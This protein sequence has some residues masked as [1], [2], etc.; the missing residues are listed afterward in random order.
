MNANNKNIGI[1][2]TIVTVVL[3]GLPA[4][5]GLCLAMS[6]LYSGVTAGGGVVEMTGDEQT[7]LLVSGVA[8]LC[9]SVVFL[10]IPILVGFFTFRK[11]PTPK[12]VIDEP[13][14]PA[15]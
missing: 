1:V 14:P 9:I 2:A 12:P 8:T 11:K 10:L 5:I 4:L 3:C 15:S 13:I 6:F 7:N